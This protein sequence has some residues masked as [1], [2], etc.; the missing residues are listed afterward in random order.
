MLI[1]SCGISGCGK[2]TYGEKLLK[3]IKDL[4][5]VCPDDI[6]KTFGD[7]S[8]Q[9]NNKQVFKIVTDTLEELFKENKI[10]YYS[11]TNL[12]KS[13]RKNI[14]QLCKKYNQEIILVIFNT[15]WRPDICEERVG[16]D[17]ILKKDR[18]NTLVKDEDGVNVIRKQFE[19]WKSMITHLNDLETEIASYSSNY[20]IKQLECE[21]S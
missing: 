5:I 1:M 15:S 16:R 14:L 4:I 17:I 11:A 19:K 2:T 18:S 12:T 9:K 8:S 3:I 10:V 13:S 6:R 21:P 7:I 20:R